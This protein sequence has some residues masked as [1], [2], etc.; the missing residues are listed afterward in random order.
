MQ[1][2]NRLVLAPV[3]SV[4]DRPC[5]GLYK[6]FG[7]GLTVSEIINAQTIL[8]NMAKAAP[9]FTPAPGESP[10]SVQLTD[11][12]PR[13]L[14]DAVRRVTDAVEGIDFIDF[15][16]GCP[17]RNV[18]NSGNGVAMM[19]SPEVVEACV[20]AMA[21]ASSVPVT[22]KMRTGW[23]A[24]APNAVDIARISVDAGAVMV[25]VH[26]RSYRQGFTG[27][28]DYDVMAAVVDAVPVPVIGNGGIKCVRDAE[29]MVTR[30]GCHAVMVATGAFGNPWLLSSLLAG[31]DTAPTIDQR[32]DIM[33][34]HLR[35]SVEE[36][37]EPFGVLRMRKHMA[38]YMKGLPQAA[39]A[40]RT[41]MTI[42][43]MHELLDYLDGYRAGIVQS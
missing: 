35:R 16:M 19:K 23:E 25:A 13:R 43:D 36:A 20:Q 41:V 31:M 28:V 1:V 24:N 32:F 8:Q 21:K 33:K 37:G 6:R 15:N 5:R 26:G 14:H 11:H 30:T 4:F 42:T 34:E 2:P 40:R 10:F 29:E 12:D 38:W 3:D 9:L 17:S 39:A 22:V 18:V 7:P 27:P